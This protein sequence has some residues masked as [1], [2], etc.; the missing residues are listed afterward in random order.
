LFKELSILHKL[1]FPHP[2]IFATWWCK[3]RLFDLK[4]F[5]VWNI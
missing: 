3:R 4:E 2:F 5:I 1:K